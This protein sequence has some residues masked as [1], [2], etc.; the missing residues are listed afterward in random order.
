MRGPTARPAAV[1][2]YNSA[3]VPIVDMSAT[4]AAGA[5]TL[6][7][8]LASLQGEQMFGAV[9]SIRILASRSF[10]AKDKLR[11]AIGQGVLSPYSCPL[12]TLVLC[13][14]SA[15]LKPP[16]CVTLT[17]QIIPP[18]RWVLKFSCCKGRGTVSRPCDR[19]HSAVHERHISGCRT[20]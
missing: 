4:E 7:E 6:L 13:A 19:R 3:I 2:M 9:R 14:F 8:T 5:D 10:A 12:I 18:L 11:S 1:D 16:S 20:N 17:T 15:Q